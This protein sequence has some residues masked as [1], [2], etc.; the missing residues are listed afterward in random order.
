M[1]LDL[2]LARWETGEISSEELER[3]HP[4]SAIAPLVTLHERLSAITEEPVSDA[5]DEMERM[6]QQLPG[7]EQRGGRRSSRV[8]LL[9]ATAVLLTASMAVAM[10]GVRSG[11]SGLAHSVSR[12]LG[13]DHVSPPPRASV[14]IGRGHPRPAGEAGGVHDGEDTQ[15]SNGAGSADGDE[16]SGDTSEAPGSGDEQGGPSESSGEDSSGGDGG[17]RDQGS[18]DQ[19]S[20]SQDS[21]SQDSDSQGSD[22]ESIGGDGGDQDSQTTDSQATDGQATDGQSEQS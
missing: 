22:G 18:D 9:A 4:H 10:P 3:L 7:R 1:S 14:T 13:A 16:P 11:V 8:L 21:D 2:D 19:G 17:S 6:L 12:L 20:D 15:G 5:E